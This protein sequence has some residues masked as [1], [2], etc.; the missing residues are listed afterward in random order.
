MCVTGS[1][2]GYIR[3]WPLDF[4]DFFLEAEHESPVMSVAMAN[5]GLSLAVGTQNGSIGVMEMSTQKYKTIVRSH[6]S[7][8]WGIAIDPH[9]NEFS[10]ISKDR[11]IRVWDM[12]NYT[13]Q[14]QF[15]TV[16]E[17]PHAITYHPTQYCIVVGFNT[18]I[19]RIFDVA[20]TAVIEEY[21][22]HSSAVYD[23]AYTKD[24]R[25]LISASQTS[26]CISDSHHLYQPVKV[27]TFMNVITDPRRV[28]ISVAP[29][30]SMFAS[31]GPSGNI[32]HLFN[33]T[34]FEEVSLFETS[35]PDLFC[36]VVFDAY[37][38]ELLS[39]TSD[40]RIVRIGIESGQILSEIVSDNYVLLTNSLTLMM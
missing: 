5:D 3:V 21:K 25:W 12:H 32:I 4:S 9:R 38:K 23:L 29:S 13:Q 24:T 36:K 2:D 19:I 17:V 10:T 18:G 31:V 40:N 14:Y 30:G 16:G 37:S 33:T 6:T 28:S 26:I 34:N 35:S 1:D 15:D 27:M 7:D 11:T 20:A 8:V 39:P 22:A